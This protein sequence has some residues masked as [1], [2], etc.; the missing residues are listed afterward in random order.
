MNYQE[1]AP[2]GYGP[3]DAETGFVPGYAF[4]VSGTP[5]VLGVPLYMGLN[6]AHS[7]ANM[8]YKAGN[9][10]TLDDAHF[11]TVGGK[12]GVPFY[13]G[14]NGAVVPYVSGGYRHWNRNLMGAGGYDEVYSNEYAGLGVSAYY[15]LNSRFVVGANIHADLIVGGHVRAYDF[16]VLRPGEVID[17]PF[18]DSASESV[19]L[20]ANYRL[21]KVV[22]LYGDIGYAHLHYTGG[23]ANIPGIFE[24]ASQTNQVSVGAGVRVYF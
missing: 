12:L 24:P 23:A 14:R 9:F 18:G 21:N 8:T 17:A 6:Y 11:Y 7:G 4:T 1:A 10:R 22:G 19:G 5:D 16:P 20:S 13:F 15:A 2:E 3:S